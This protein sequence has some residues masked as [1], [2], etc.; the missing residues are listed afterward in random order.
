MNTT[1][2]EDARSRAFR[3][4]LGKLSERETEIFKR[5]AQGE[6]AADIARTLGLT[7]S[8]VSTYR[9]RI[10]TKLHQRSNADLTVIAYRLGIIE[11]PDLYETVSK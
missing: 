4:L 1:I 6:S 9:R 5:I 3:Y 7:H 8:T 11:A 10:L 2:A